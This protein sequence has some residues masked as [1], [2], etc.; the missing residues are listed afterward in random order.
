MLCFKIHF[1]FPGIAQ[2]PCPN[3]NQCN[4]SSNSSLYISNQRR[5]YYVSS[6]FLFLLNRWAS[7]PQ[8]NP[9]AWWIKWSVTLVSGRVNITKVVPNCTCQHLQSCY[10]SVTLTMTHNKSTYL[11]LRNLP[12][13]RVREAHKHQRQPGSSERQQAK[14]TKQGIWVPATP[15][16]HHN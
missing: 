2:T 6:I 1:S 5:I 13:H 16:V 7:L 3:S 14:Q 11:V 8:P 10:H 4:A 9:P 15:Y 12:M